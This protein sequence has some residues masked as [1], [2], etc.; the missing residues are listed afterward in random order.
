[1]DKKK[2]AKDFSRSPCCIKPVIRSFP[3]LFVSMA[4]SGHSLLLTVVSKEMTSHQLL[5]F[6]IIDMLNS[7]PVTIVTTTSLFT[8]SKLLNRDCHL[9]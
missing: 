3:F 8:S 4:S 6:K 9:P 7:I 2:P 1:M 5:L